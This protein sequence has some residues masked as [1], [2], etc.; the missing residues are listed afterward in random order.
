MNIKQICIKNHYVPIPKYAIYIKYD[1]L[2]VWR[3]PIK[4][5]KKKNVKFIIKIS[6]VELSSKT[7][8]DFEKFHF[9]KGSHGYDVITMWLNHDSFE[10]IENAYFKDLMLEISYL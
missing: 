6:V 5:S 7:K 4:I 10:D 1:N 2:V 8:V 9:E 3:W